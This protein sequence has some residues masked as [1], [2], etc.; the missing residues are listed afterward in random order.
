MTESETTNDE[1][2]IKLLAML[3]RGKNA[4]YCNDA[5]EALYCLAYLG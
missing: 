1:S 3:T 5:A 2:D 4:K